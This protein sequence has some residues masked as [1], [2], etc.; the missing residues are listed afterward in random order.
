MTENEPDFPKWF[1]MRGAGMTLKVSSHEVRQLFGNAFYCRSCGHGG[2]RPD[3]MHGKKCP[4]GN[5]YS[6]S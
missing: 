6:E 2:G 5:P 4:H 3:F 1:L